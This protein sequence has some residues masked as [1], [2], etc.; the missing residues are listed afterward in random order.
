MRRRAKFKQSLLWA[1]WLTDEV[2]RS[3]HDPAQLSAFSNNNIHSY[4]GMYALP[5]SIAPDITSATIH[6]VDETKRSKK[7]A[8]RDS[9]LLL[10]QNA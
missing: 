7:R 5:K 8:L 9:P 6:K 2:L 4:S 10:G 1:L 3:S